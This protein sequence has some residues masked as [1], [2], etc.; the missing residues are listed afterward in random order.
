MDM[1]NL[2]WHCDSSLQSLQLSIE[3]NAQSAK[4]VLSHSKRNTRYISNDNVGRN[5]RRLLTLTSSDALRFRTLVNSCSIYP[6]PRQANEILK[7]REIPEEPAFYKHTLE[8]AK[9]SERRK[10]AGEE[11]LPVRSMINGELEMVI[12]TLTS[13]E[14]YDGKVLFIYKRKLWT[15]CMSTLWISNDTMSPL[16]KILYDI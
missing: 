5:W 4:V 13:K 16:S 10:R 11:G 2:R 14:I 3:H 8:D 6:Q 1:P 12:G 15:N 9:T 7:S